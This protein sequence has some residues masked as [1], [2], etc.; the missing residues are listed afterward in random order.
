MSTVESSSTCSDNCSTASAKDH[1]PGSIGRPHEA[2]GHR[3]GVPPAP[4]ESQPISTLG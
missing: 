2:N 1:P 4:R 3:R